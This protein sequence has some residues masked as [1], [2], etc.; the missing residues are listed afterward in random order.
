MRITV[1]LVLLSIQAFGQDAWKNIYSSNAWT[2]RDRWQRADEL[3]RLLSL[4]KSAHVADIGCHEGYMT[5]KLSK[6]VGAQGKVY[7][8]DVDQ[9]KLDK[10]KRSV[11][12]R[13]IT[14]IEVIKGDYDDPKLPAQKLDAVVILDTYHEMDD[15]DVILQHIKSS[16]KP[17]GRLLLCEPIADE[18]KKLKRSE[19][20]DKHELGMQYALED[21]EKAGF[22]ITYKKDPFV[23]RTKEKGDKMWVIVCVPKE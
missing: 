9:S 15:H 23:D 6:E 12:D 5:F 21:L 4:G 14:N 1:V 3:I 20:E 22:T 18:R 7:A 8:V 16:L 13:K 19:Q 11:S 2:E 10:L 17:G